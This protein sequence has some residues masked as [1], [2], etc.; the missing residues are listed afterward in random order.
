M[1]YPPA[2][3]EMPGLRSRCGDVPLSCLVSYEDFVPRLERNALPGG[4]MYQVTQVPD[5]D[6]ANHLMERVREYQV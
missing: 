2:I 1:G 5:A 4:V 3:D 6:T